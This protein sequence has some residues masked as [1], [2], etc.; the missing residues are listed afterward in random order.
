MGGA[1]PL[2]VLMAG[3]VLLSTIE[4]TLATTGDPFGVMYAALPSWLGV[5]Y[6]L[7]AAGGSF[8]NA[9]S[10]YGQRASIWQPS[11]LTCHS[12]HHC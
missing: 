5:I 12:G 4:P 11:A 1:V 8:R 10:R 7:V 2:F 6:F 9:S 3:G